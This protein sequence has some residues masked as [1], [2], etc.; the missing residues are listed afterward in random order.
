[1][2][3]AHEM[4]RRSREL[5]EHRIGSIGSTRAKTRGNKCEHSTALP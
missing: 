4:E 2:A 1:M 5:C 3:R